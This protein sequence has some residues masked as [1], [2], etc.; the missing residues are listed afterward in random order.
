MDQ[1][2]EDSFLTMVGAVA[3]L[4]SVSGLAVVIHCACWLWSK[5]KKY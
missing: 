4:L 2:L 3:M 5:F 1:F